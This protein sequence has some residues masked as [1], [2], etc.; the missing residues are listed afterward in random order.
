VDGLR[1]LIRTRLSPGQRAAARLTGRPSATARR[2]R[3]A[4]SAPARELPRRHRQG[5][6]LL[7]GARL[8]DVGEC[9]RRSRPWGGPVPCA[10]FGHR[11][12]AA[13][14]EGTGSS[15]ERHDEAGEEHRRWRDGGGRHERDLRARWSPAATA[16][17]GSLPP[18]ETAGDWRCCTPWRL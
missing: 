2:D 15:R 18:S 8:G 4:G 12:S 17:H 3:P 5:C 10:P 7:A 16:I 14:W 9:V 13:R 11:G 6:R 1:A